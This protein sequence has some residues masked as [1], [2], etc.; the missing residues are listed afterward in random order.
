MFDSY[1]MVSQFVI[2]FVCE[3]FF[4]GFFYC[5]LSEMTE[6]HDLMGYAHLR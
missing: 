5:I 1:L 2:R 4:H 6:V 3:G